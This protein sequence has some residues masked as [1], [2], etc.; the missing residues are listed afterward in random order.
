MLHL[1]PS[2]AAGNLTNIEKDVRRLEP[3]CTGFHLD[4]MDFH[5]VPNLTFGPDFINVVRAITDKRLWVH[6][7]VDEPDRYI[8]L[9]RLA[10]GDIVSVHGE[11]PS[12]RACSGC[13]CRAYPA[14]YVTKI[15]RDLHAR[16]L[17]ASLAIK[18]AT[19]V[20]RV[21]DFLDCIDHVLLMSVEPGFS[22]QAFMPETYERLSALNALRTQCGKHFD[23]GTDGGIGPEI[24]RDLAKR[25]ANDFAVASAIF[26]APDPLKAA[27]ELHKLM[28]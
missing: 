14:D 23:I 11:Y 13:A 15:F 21:R 25:G 10:P 19:P 7:M 3:Y 26:A 20:D 22:G 1:Y 24:I 8:P 12:A 2:L 27:Q 17:T 28:L 16:G 4:V 6:L 18:P 5:F 9:M